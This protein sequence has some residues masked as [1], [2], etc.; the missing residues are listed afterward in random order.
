MTGVAPIPAEVLDAVIEAA[1]ALPA[2]ALAAVTERL[3]AGV[4]SSQVTEPL[5]L[6]ASRARVT[7]LV[8]RWRSAVGAG[9]DAELA[10]ALEGASAMQAWHRGNVR[11]E[12]VWTGPVPDRTLLRRTD[13]AL[14]ELI[15]GARASLLLVSFAA[16]RVPALERALREAVGRGVAV[17]FVLESPADSDGRVSSDPLDAVGEALLRDVTVWSWPPAERPPDA[18]GRRGVLHAKCAL[19]D[20]RRLFVSSA[21]LTAAAWSVNMELGVIVEGGTLPAEVG[22]HFAR[23]MGAGVLQRTS[24]RL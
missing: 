14:L 18:H 7:A 19:A 2:E 20:G 22:E 6:D 5:A 3:R 10:A 21:N 4:T 17:D 1:R 15:H 8:A 16:Y 12:L 13:Q 11:H 9:R 24:G 23:L